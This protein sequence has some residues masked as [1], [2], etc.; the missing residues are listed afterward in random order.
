MDLLIDIGNSQLKWATRGQANSGRGWFFGE[1]SLHGG[2]YQACIAA[3]WDELPKPDRVA[4]SCVAS[5]KASEVADQRVA[6]LWGM[7]I[8]HLSNAEKT[9]NISSRYAP[10]ELGVDRWLSVIGARS[11]CEGDLVVADFGSAVNIEFLSADNQYLGGMILPGRALMHHSLLNGT[12]IDSGSLDQFDGQLGESTKAAI[13]AGVISALTGALEKAIRI[14]E[15]QHKRKWRA[16]ITGGDSSMLAPFLSKQYVLEPNLVF[17]GMSEV[18][19]WQ[20]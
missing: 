15:Q 10:N 14:A 1:P 11:L 18:L 6:S 8:R 17:I 16:I 9:F 3:L 13:S 20:E 19:N 12:A 2:D 4:L 5:A 7:D